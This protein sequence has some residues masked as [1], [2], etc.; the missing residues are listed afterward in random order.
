MSSDK[1]N[2]IDLF[3]GCGGL[4]FGFEKTN[5]YETL[6]FLE[7]DKKCCETLTK[8]F[9]HIEKKIINE[10]IR[11]TDNVIGN[12]MHK[13]KKEIPTLNDLVDGQKVNLVI[14]GPPCQAYSIA[15]R[16]R[17][18]HGMKNDYR[19]YLFESYL[20]IVEHFRPEFF[21][22]ENVQ[23]ML[24]ARPGNLKITEI[25]K[26]EFLKIGYTIPSDLK[27]CLLDFSLFGLPQK[28]KRLIIMGL[29][30]TSPLF[31]NYN[32]KD[33]IFKIFYDLVLPNYHR[34]PQN[35][36]EVINDLPKFYP[37]K[38]CNNGVVYKSDLP[39]FSDHEPRNQNH[40]DVRIFKTLAED[41]EKKEFKFVKTKDLIKLYEKEVGKKT[42]FH[43]YYVLR[44]DS[45]S[46]TIPAHLS[47]DG[48]RHIHYDSKQSRTITVREAARLQGFPD[49]FSFAGNISQKFRMIGNAVPPLFSK[50]LAN[51]LL[52][53]ISMLKS[54]EKYS[55]F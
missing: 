53:L 15:G 23:G 51:S 2:I 39:F 4:S 34:N 28:R 12:S 38:N 33:E 6:A 55:L 45:V 43:K 50:I 9:R 29:N 16:V 24:S 1:L 32:S 8:N 31:S 5:R 52:D 20:K 46:N 10:D 14:G 27:M 54:N 18:K 7:I 21:L 37:E 25:V 3:S 36:M 30:E 40:R 47:V 42:K 41:I 13:A 22:F 35:V 11:Q 44:R 49:N 26:K 17:D 19:N 48:L